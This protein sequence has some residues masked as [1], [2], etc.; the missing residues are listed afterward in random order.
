MFEARAATAAMVGILLS[1]GVLTAGDAARIEWR[2]N[3]FT[4]STQSEA[5]LAVDEAGRVF[6]AWSSRRQQGGRY[7][8]Y[9]RWFGPDGTPLSSEITI[10]GWTDSHQRRPAV[11]MLG[12]ADGVQQP[13][14]VWASH[15]QDGDGWGIFA[16]AIDGGVELPVNL[17]GRGDQTMPVLATHPRAASG[18]VVWVSSGETDDEDDRTQLR[19]RRIDASGLGLYLDVSDAA[20]RVQST[21][22]AAVNADGVSAIAWSVREP[23]T[24]DLTLAVRCFDPDGRARDTTTLG[25]PGA[26][27]PA[28]AAID[29]G[30]AAAWIEPMTS[31]AGH[32]VWAQRLDANGTPLAAAVPT[33]ANADHQYGVAVAATGDGGFAVAWNVRTQR[34]DGDVVVRRY[35]PRGTPLGGAERLSGFSRG[36]QELAP[37][38]VTRLVATPGETLLGVWSGNGTGDGSGVYVTRHGTAGPSPTPPLD[39]IAVRTQL[40]APHAPPTFDPGRTRRPDSP[41][42]MVVGDGSFGFDAVFDTGWDPPDPH[43]AVGV[44]HLV[45]MTNGAIAFFTKSGQLTFEDEIEGGGGF[46]GSLG[47]SGFIFDPEVIYDPMTDRF[48]AMASDRDTGVGRSYV[49]LAISDDG[50]P[51]GVWFKHRLETTALAGQT[52][53]SPNIAVDDS[54]VYVTGD[55]GGGGG[56]TY[57]VFMYDKASLIAG[58]PPAITRSALLPTTTE[59]AGIPPVVHG[60]APA[61]YMVEHGEGSSNAVRL[62]ALQDPLGTPTF[63]TMFLPVSSY[64]HP[65]D[66]PQAGTGVRPETFDARFWSAAY[67]DGSLW[68]T[69]HVNSSRVV[70]RWYEIA[71]NGWPDSGQEPELLQEGTITPAATARTFFSAITP[72]RFGNAALVYSQSSPTDFI[73]MQTAFRFQSDLVNKMQ[74]GVERRVNTGP[75]FTNRWGDYARIQVDPVDGKTFWAHHEYATSGGSW[76]TWVHAFTPAFPTGDATC[77]GVVDFEDLLTVLAAWGPC[78]APPAACPGDVDG[79]GSVG[80]SDLLAVLSGWS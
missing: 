64:T 7:G 58:N 49:L 77:N 40:P 27:E 20:C 78:P 12:D 47:A 19:A 18:V 67:R 36:G 71:M 10:N 52:F 3:E 69:H 28:I 1:A 44:D 5:T 51:N 70:V 61:L 57:P 42:A 60:D 25:G 26:T 63:T 74:P 72:D 68:A 33:D 17:D 6:V 65:E 35:G 9:G 31:G 34:D 54:V 38:G 79:D 56:P 50:D 4:E 55:R 8:V 32:R 76:R 23:G 43:M 73:S 24:T 22:A 41:R 11:A 29:G 46:W 66:P 80:F 15:G 2:A 53:D 39:A 45:V 59:S 13:W 21:P 14:A 75:W 62:I 30:F 37:S 16:R 48:I